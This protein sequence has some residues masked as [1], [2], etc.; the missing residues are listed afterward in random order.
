LNGIPTELPFVKVASAAGEQLAY[1]VSADWAPTRT[2]FLTPETLPLQMGMIVYNKDEAI[3]P[4]VHLPITRSV[5][6]TSECIVVRKGRCL[7]DIFDSN[8]N[9]VSTHEL[10]TGT[11]ILL[12]GGGH[13]FRMLEDTVLFEVKQG[14]Y[15]G[16]LDKARF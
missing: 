2:T 15:A 11:I 3:T 5:E 12:L 8:K 9:F 13:G 7:I 16:D 10:K 6:G 14:P 1:I 4:H